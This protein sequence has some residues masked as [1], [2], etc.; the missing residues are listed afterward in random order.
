MPE[1][2]NGW[3]SIKRANTLI[4]CVVG[5]LT[6]IGTVFITVRVGV[7]QE[8]HLEFEAQIAQPASDLNRHIDSKF[9]GTC[10]LER[11]NVTSR[12]RA[13]EQDLAVLKAHEEAQT[14][15]IRELRTDIKEL[16]RRTR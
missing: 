7:R 4:A 14:E 10:A 13:V 6:I 8:V 16:L 3:M 15:E 1:R 2:R 11:A 12:L 9:A 5:L